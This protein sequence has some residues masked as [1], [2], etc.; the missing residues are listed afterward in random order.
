MPNAF[1]ISRKGKRI[2]NETIYTK[3]KIIKIQLIEF[4]GKLY[5]IKRVNGIMKDFM[6]VTP[7]AKKTI[8]E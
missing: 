8:M 2:R 1:I 6:E 7:N 4:D 3:S 5:W